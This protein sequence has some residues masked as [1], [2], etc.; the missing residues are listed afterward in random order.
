M[1]SMIYVHHA[2]QLIFL[3]PSRAPGP[4]TEYH[5]VQPAFAFIMPG[6]QIHPL[7]LPMGCLFLSHS[8][9]R[10]LVGKHT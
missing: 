5:L 6:F 2:S 3:E 1:D 10:W 9:P 4:D 7:E 8:L